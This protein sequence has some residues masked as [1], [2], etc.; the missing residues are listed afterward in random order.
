MGVKSKPGQEGSVPGPWCPWGSLQDALHRKGCGQPRE[1]GRQRQQTPE[2]DG[3]SPGRLETLDPAGPEPTA[4]SFLK[5]S[6]LS[7]LSPPPLS[8]SSSL[9]LRPLPLSL[10][11]L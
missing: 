9:L 3:G 7:L 10:S 1:R 4:F 8:P 11:L 2:S 6:L 5:I